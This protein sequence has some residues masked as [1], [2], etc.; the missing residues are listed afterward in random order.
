M[1]HNVI[2]SPDDLALVA[3]ITPE[4]IES[5]ERES[6]AV[7][8]LAA[9]DD[10]CPPRVVRCALASL[11]CAPPSAA[12]AVL[13]HMFDLCAERA[14]RALQGLTRRMEANDSAAPAQNGSGSMLANGHALQ[15][16]TN[17]TPPEC[18][19]AA[20]PLRRE[21]AERWRS[22]WEDP[23][24][25]EYEVSLTRPIGLVLRPSSPSVALSAAATEA[26]A[27]EPVGAATAMGDSSAGGQSADERPPALPAL[28]RSAARCRRTRRASTLRA[29]CARSSSCT[30]PTGCTATSSS[31]T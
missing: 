4:L 29:S 2:S 6:T 27:P 11:A 23:V 24:K 15:N 20:A 5:R 30:A 14:Q 19:A 3:S 16:A 8:A 21:R 17:G 7:I 10:G 18:L 13:S 28:G 26:A 22:R 9:L 12:G 31:R 1:A 25:Y